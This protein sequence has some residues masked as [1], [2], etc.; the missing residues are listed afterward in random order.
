MK[1][2]QGGGFLRCRSKSFNDR[3][4][5]AYFLFFGRGGS[6]KNRC[7]KIETPLQ[8]RESIIDEKEHG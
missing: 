8:F 5:A 3:R 2:A 6:K 4:N 7:T 1:Y